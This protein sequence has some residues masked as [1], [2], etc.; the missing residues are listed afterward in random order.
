M[1]CENTTA[2]SV[3]S[4]RTIG[5]FLY[6]VGVHH[7]GHIFLAQERGGFQFGAFIADGVR[8]P[9]MKE[10]PPIIQKGVLFHR[11][12]DWQTDRHPAFLAAR[13]LLRPVAG[14]YAG[15]IV[16]L[17]LD[18]VLGE[19]WHELSTEPLEAFAEGFIQETLVPH[20]QWVPPTWHG[21]VESL[22][23]EGLLLRFATAEG[24]LAH[25]E[26][27]IQRRG[28]PIQAEVVQKALETHQPALKELLGRFWQD[29]QSWQRRADTF[30]QKP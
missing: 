27:F 12:V 14:R 9:R 3:R 28:L 6:L 25:I 4:C 29:A 19:K 10:L 20:R 7:L 22:E 24:M 13:R 5:D 16:D 21:L 11:W 23:R 2:S 30:A 1:P 18:V 8:A 17:W 15:L 26:R